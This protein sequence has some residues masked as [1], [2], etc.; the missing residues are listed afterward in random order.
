LSWQH[1]LKFSKVNLSISIEVKHLEGYLKVA[2][3]GCREWEGAGG[4]V[5]RREERG[6]GRRGGEGRRGK[7]A[8]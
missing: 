7:R 5:R 3:W 1:L 2:H 6:S 4:V 8:W